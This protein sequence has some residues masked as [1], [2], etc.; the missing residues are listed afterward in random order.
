[1][2]TLYNFRSFIKAFILLGAIGVSGLIKAQDPMFT[3]FYNNP[4]YY[5]PGTAGL[6]PGM[7]VR[8]NYRD[9][10]PNLPNNFK[11]YSFN[12]DIA[13]R[14]IPG[15]GGLGL[16]FLNDKAGAGK[17]QTTS[18]GLST[19]ARVPI[20]E[21]SVAQVGFSVSFVQKMINWNDLVFSDQLNPR[22]GNINPT[23]FQA[24]DRSNVTYPDFAVGGVYRFSETNLSITGIQG[25]F[26]VAVH[27]VFR[28]NESLSGLNTRLPRK[29]VVHGDLVL[30]VNQSYRSFYN[31]INNPKSLMLN[32]GF[33]YEKQGDFS[34]FSIGVNVLQ[35]SVYTTGI[36]FRNQIFDF[37]KANDLMFVVGLYL[38]FN[39]GSRMKI[40]YSYDLILTA[41]RP[42]AGAAHEVTISFE[43][44]DLSLF[45][46]GDAYG[47]TFGS[48]SHER[49]RYHKLKCYPF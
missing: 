18:V 34:T 24:P 25:T 47:N 45:G 14:S 16:I 35:S 43:F 33:I 1:M 4:L 40:I 9:Q 44:D 13:E 12:M 7:R 6:N 29:L 3:Q 20:Q 22:Y 19:A 8:I 42:A 37:V 27:H 11:T 38:P 39:K 32:P 28:P 26:G 48:S 41:L 10:W 2:K 31:R 36:W 49:R 46:G 30:D 17:L 21:N 15:S 5:N 23:A